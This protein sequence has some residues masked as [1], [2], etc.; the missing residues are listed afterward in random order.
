[1]VQLVHDSGWTRTPSW[2]S[3]L[4]V[5]DLAVLVRAWSS[6]SGVGYAR[7][8][9]AAPWA[10]LGEYGTR[11]GARRWQ[12]GAF[13]WAVQ[14]SSLPTLPAGDG[15]NSFRL[16]VFRDTRGVGRA[17]TGAAMVPTLP[18]GGAFAVG[19]NPST[20][21]GLTVLPG[22]SGGV[23]VGWGDAPAGGTIGNPGWDHSHTR[24]YELLPPAGPSS[25]VPLS[26]GDGDEVANT[27]DVVFG[28][29]HRPSVPG[30]RQ[31]AYRLRVVADGGEQ[32]Y[33]SASTGAF[34][35]SVVTNLS[36][37]EGVDIDGSRFAA[38]VVH[39]WHVQTR[40]GV[41]GKWS[42]WSAGAGF[43]PVSPPSV[44]VTGP[45]DVHDDL[46]PVV[47][48]S[49][50]TPRGVQTAFRVQV[51]R[52]GII[53]HDSGVQPGDATE[54]Q[55]PVLD[56]VNGDLY[57]VLV[58]VQQTGGS[59]SPWSTRDFVVSW[60]TPEAPV[61]RA[62]PDRDG[63]RVQVTAQPGVEVELER[64][65]EQGLWVRVAAPFEA[66]AGPVDVVDVLAP[67]GVATAYRARAANVLDGMPLT[68]EPGLSGPVRST[69]RHS[70]LAAAGD[71]ASTW[72]RLYI[73]GDDP[74]V[75]A[76]ASAVA[77]GLGD[78]YGRI[79][80][81]AERGLTGS[82]T[83][84][85]L[86][87]EDRVKLLGLLQSREPLVVRWPAEAADEGPGF[88]DAGLTVFGVA[89]AVARER[90]SQQV[91][92]QR[93][94]LSVPWIEQPAVFGEGSSA[95]RLH[96]VGAGPIGPLDVA[97]GIDIIDLEEV[98]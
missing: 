43:A 65:T 3:G 82:F 49:S 88:V 98:L 92:T 17:R 26:P 61:V 81:G 55:V 37:V 42:P 83:V 15:F 25:P 84:H 90:L 18:G 32:Q 48:W 12:A 50:V 63:V 57:Q 68:S 87:Q 14:P 34:S 8:S 77:Y 75:P 74:Q 52:L 51:A 11:T 97:A 70:Y 80:F 76:T 10:T 9:P 95:P 28:W 16:L 73:Q 45:D 72:V 30:G 60:T 20:S 29:Q 94:V 2:P 86:T 78:D 13:Q 85:G 31:D 7:V 24:A 39:E 23:A 27:G 47:S 53:V 40:E 56:W 67:Y 4:Q 62:W 54:W 46:A 93:R 79:S 91:A 89:S 58:Q 96:R 64:V 35:S 33:W 36:T 71:P 6:L 5:G 22:L 38:N 21:G 19:V 69:A 1:M 66:T 59:W 41:D 44:S